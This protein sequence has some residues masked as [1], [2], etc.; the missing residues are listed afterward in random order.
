M[1]AQQVEYEAG[2]KLGWSQGRSG[3]VNLHL[4]E[5]AEITSSYITGYTDA[6]QAGYLDAF[7]EG[8]AETSATDLGKS[9][10]VFDG[11]RGAQKKS[12]ELR[13]CCPPKKLTQPARAGFREAF[14][15]A[16]HIG[17][18][19]GFQ[20]KKRLILAFEEDVDAQKQG[21]SR[22]YCDGVI[23]ARGLKPRQKLDSESKLLWIPN[24]ASYCRTYDTAYH[25]A[26][27]KAFLDCKLLKIS[28]IV[29]NN[30]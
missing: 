28:L 9:C 16:Y 11:C 17:Y 7:E 15:N 10:G 19:D 5:T 23:A 30:T 8:S 13:V 27:R 24:M 14:D 29:E 6:W 2:L 12:P 25:Q 3:V 26:F 4:T 22:G 21:K 20:S 18:N 1:T